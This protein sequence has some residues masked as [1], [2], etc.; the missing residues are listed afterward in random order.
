MVRAGVARGDITA[1]VGTYLTGFAGRPGPS[2]GVHDSLEA[3]VLVLESA[4]TK[5]ALICA[6][7]LT[8]DD[9]LVERITGAVYSKAGIAPDNILLCASHTHSGP[10]VR[11]IHGMGAPDVEYL[12]CAADKIVGAVCQAAEQMAPVRVGAGRAE[13]SIGVNRRR[14]TD[15]GIALAPEPSKPIDPDLSVLRVDD[16]AGKPIC[17]LFNHACH[18][19]VL[20]GN[21]TLIS[22]DWIGYA[23]RGI[24]RRFA[25]VAASAFDCPQARGEAAPPVVMFAQGACADIN[26]AEMGTFEMA[27]RQGERVAEAVA[28]LVPSIETAP[29]ERVEAGSVAFEMPLLPLPSVDEARKEVADAE[30]QVGALEKEG[31]PIGRINGA[32]ALVAWAERLVEAAQRGGAPPMRSRVTAVSLDGIALVGLPG[33]VFCEIGMNIRASSPFARTFVIAYANR[34]LGYIPTRQ[35]YDEGGYEVDG[36]YKYY[37]IAKVAPTAQG[38]LEQAAADVLGALARR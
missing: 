3:Q 15:T 24:E 1:P 10:A 12:D 36:A 30:R 20:G 38:A 28:A 22:A 25:R 19:V 4:G 6:D 13:V 29:V 9:R 17:I 2:T 14:R 33:E 18:G 34:V 11:A 16:Q 31:A 7:I 21:N 27:Q 35:A 23:R 8:F 32:K 26:P 37:G 5:A